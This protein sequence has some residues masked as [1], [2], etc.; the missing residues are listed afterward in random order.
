MKT[1]KNRVL[2]FLTLFL[3][4]SIS[5]AGGLK[6]YMSYASFNT[7]DNEPYLETYL[8]VKGSSIKHIINENGKFQGGVEVQ[9]I[10]RENDSIVNFSKYSLNGPAISDTLSGFPNFLD[11]QRYA[12][13]NGTYEIELKINDPNSNEE[14]IVSFDKYTLNYDKPADFS[15][16]QLVESMK[17]SENPSN[18]TRNGYDV[19]PYVFTFYPEVVNTLTFYSEFYNDNK[20]NEDF[21]ISYYLKSLDLNKRLDNYSVIKRQKPNQ[22]NPIVGKFDI[23]SLPS[24]K[25]LLVIE[26]RNKENKLMSAKQTYFQ[27]S[28]PKVKLEMDDYLIDGLEPVLVDN[29]NNTDSLLKYLQ[30]IEPISSELEKTF[31]QSLIKADEPNS[32]QMR[33]YFLTFWMKRN[34]AEPISAWRD[35]KAV[36]MKVNQGFSTQTTPGFATDRGRVF[37]KY[38]APNSIEQYYFESNTYPYEIWHYYTLPDNQRD[39]TFVF[40]T[41]DIVTND[42]A[43]VHSNA[44]GELY[45][46]KWTTIVSLP[47]RGGAYGDVDEFGREVEYWGGNRNINNT[48][49]TNNR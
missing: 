24:G 10:F 8:T 16:I 11:V 30:W 19:Y 25:Y 47:A 22:I 40:Y 5:F 38:G 43:L 28:N 34:T 37:L 39:K 33:N 44:I 18:F 13:G 45:N 4:S 26:A 20:I 15:D 12:L 14:P 49:R 21:I 1:M 3:I 23:S 27:R 42:F 31:A 32:E 29:M 35:Y 2:I 36:V 46:Y 17:K 41:H 6:A 9:I 48:I 7:P